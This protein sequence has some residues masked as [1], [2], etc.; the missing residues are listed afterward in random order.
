MSNET[1]QSKDTPPVPTES[2][3]HE[4]KQIDFT[5][6]AL[7]LDNGEPCVP[8][9]KDIA[10]ELTK[11]NSDTICKEVATRSGGYYKTVTIV[12]KREK[13]IY[14]RGKFDT[15][16]TLTRQPDGAVKANILYSRSQD[17]RGCTGGSFHPFSKMLPKIV[18]DNFGIEMPLAYHSK[19]S[20]P[21]VIMN[22]RDIRD[23]YVEGENLHE[24][25]DHLYSLVVDDIP[26]EDDS[27]FSE[28][29]TSERE[30]ERENK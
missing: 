1:T 25:K 22:E 12:R 20:L 27:E 7:M 30:R 24:L 23:T 16:S 28:G 6:I 3:N 21:I 5:S 14:I 4:Y 17:Y 19:V 9:Q 11:K 2:T 8:L 29:D 13:R 15:R 10:D 18:R 26:V